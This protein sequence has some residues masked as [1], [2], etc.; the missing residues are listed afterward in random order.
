M[1]SLYL[2]LPKFVSIF[3]AIFVTVWIVWISRFLYAEYFI[4]IDIAIVLMAVSL[5]SFPVT[6]I[7]RFFIVEREKRMLTS[8]FSHYVDGRVVEKIAASGKPINL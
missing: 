3:T 8:A 6:Y 4:V 1:V 7:Y 2:L 5:I